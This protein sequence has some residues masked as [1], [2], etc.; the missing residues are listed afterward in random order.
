[1]KKYHKTKL[2]LKLKFKDNNPGIIDSPSEKVPWGSPSYEDSIV[3][4]M[5][6]YNNKII[7]KENYKMF[8]LD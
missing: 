8:I 3:S 1:M 7:L 6:I 4:R 2:K 5:I